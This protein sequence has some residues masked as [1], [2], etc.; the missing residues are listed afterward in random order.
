M[1][2]KE[3]LSAIEILAVVQS[4]RTV[5]EANNISYLYYYREKNIS[6]LKMDSISPVNHQE[7]SS[8]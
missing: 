6:G 8:V 1:L 5:H 2:F 7:L 3:P 4:V